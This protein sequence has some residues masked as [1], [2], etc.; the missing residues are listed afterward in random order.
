MRS[1]G[2]PL[3]SSLMRTRWLLTVAG[4][5][6]EGSRGSTGGGGM[7][8]RA[9]R[10]GLIPP[11]MGSGGVGRP[12]DDG[13]DTNRRGLVSSTSILIRDNGTASA[14]ATAMGDLSLGT[15]RERAGG[16]W[17]SSW[18]NLSSTIISLGDGARACAGGVGTPL[19]VSWWAGGGT[20]GDM[21]GRGSSCGERSRCG[22]WLGTPGTTRGTGE[23]HGG[24]DTGKATGVSSVTAGLQRASFGAPSLPTGLGSG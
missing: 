15:G 4:I 17:G 24:R 1:V 18:S 14:G 3:I 6:P 22:T 19:L 23:G 11:D 12:R 7:A 10:D 9:A 8:D 21:C 2:G 16:A 13:D 5:M 20:G